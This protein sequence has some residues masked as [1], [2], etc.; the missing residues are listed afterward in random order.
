MI[1]MYFTYEQLRPVL[2]VWLS[3]LTIA[4]LV[5]MIAWLSHD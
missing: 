4:G 3:T 1:N 2:A 5:L